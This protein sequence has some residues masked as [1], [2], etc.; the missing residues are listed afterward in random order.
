MAPNYTSWLQIILHGSKFYLYF[1]LWTSLTSLNHLTYLYLSNQFFRQVKGLNPAPMRSVTHLELDAFV[2][3]WP[4]EDFDSLGS[5][6]LDVQVT[7]KK[8]NNSVSCFVSTINTQSMFCV[9]S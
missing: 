1:R 2:D 7:N 5:R 8:N 3:D 6:D 4:A 9:D